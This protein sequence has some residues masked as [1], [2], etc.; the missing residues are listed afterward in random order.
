MHKTKVFLDLDRTLYRTTEAGMSK[1]Q[2]VSEYYPQVDTG[3]QHDRQHDF[4]VHDGDAYAYDFSAHLRDVGLKPDIVYGQLQSSELA[5]GRFE[6]EGTRGLINWLMPRSELA[7]LT[8]GVDDYQ[9]LKAS[10]CPS[11]VGVEI[12]TTMKPKGEFLKD[13][14][15]AWLVD[16]KPLWDELSDNIH[17]IRVRH[18]GVDESTAD[19]VQVGSLNEVLEIFKSEFIN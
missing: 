15:D 11:L 10:L 13:K 19:R 2:K 17:F 16:D 9:R 1:W 6:Y 18:D 8:Y 3:L 5:D 4:Y 7:I 12:I 14:G